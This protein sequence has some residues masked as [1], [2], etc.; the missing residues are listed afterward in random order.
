MAAAPQMAIAAN[1][2]SGDGPP[3]AGTGAAGPALCRAEGPGAIQGQRRA[4]AGA[5]EATTFLGSSPGGATA[6]SPEP[7]WRSYPGRPEQAATVRAFL[8]A[9]LAG[10]PAADDVVLMADELVS[11]AIQHSR[12][13]GPG[14]TFR[15]RLTV[16]PGSSAH[17][18]VA[19]AGG[20][21]TG[22]GGEP[23]A[24][25][26]RLR[27]RGLRIVGALAATWGVHGDETGRT[28]WF[29]A[30]WDAR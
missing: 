2:E 24:D 17:V 25:E 7:A 30:G 18:E 10:C 21:W 16:R 14:G 27:G 12:S 15:L 29:T 8:A 22:S 4:A 11:N 26:D 1:R 13:G 9:A 6:G 28:V 5:A 19:D 20:N 23:L 3:A